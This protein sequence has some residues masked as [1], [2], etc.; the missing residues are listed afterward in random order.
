MGGGQSSGQPY[1]ELGGQ[2]ASFSGGTPPS[3]QF[4]W[5]TFGHGLQSA[6]AT[7]AAGSPQQNFMSAA[8]SFA[9]PQQY[10]PAQPQ[11]QMIPQ[12]S[13]QD[14]ELQTFIDALR[15]LS[16]QGKGAASYWYVDPS[17][18]GYGANAGM[19]PAGTP[20]SF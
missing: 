2:Y 9:P 3:D 14:N 18:Q 8:S 20:P 11:T 12:A 19:L 13:G 16:S 15:R 4:N 17:A 1:D 10:Y 6:G 7:Y 5:G